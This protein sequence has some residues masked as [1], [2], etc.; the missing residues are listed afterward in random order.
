MADP[1]YRSSGK[2]NDV[3][4]SIGRV[5]L[6]DAVPAGKRLVIQTVTGWYYGDN[7]TLG[8]AL[9]TLNSMEF[10]FPWVP[11]NPC[12]G[13]DGNEHKDSSRRFYGFNHH[14]VLSA[15]GPSKL[16]FDAAGGSFF[17]GSTSHEG[18]YSVY[19]YLIDIPA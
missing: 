9:L 2:F 12:C 11:G 15:D 4:P 8:T 16:Q 3:S 14:V 18:A 10:A 7:A 6:P 17:G 1:I 5:I 13:G 19:G